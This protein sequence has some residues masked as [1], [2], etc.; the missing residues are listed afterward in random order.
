MITIAT[1][2]NDDEDI[3]LSI[4]IIAKRQV[5][6]DVYN[7]NSHKQVVHFCNTFTRQNK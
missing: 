6:N 4:I 1:Q 2:E 5:Q 3:I 7:K